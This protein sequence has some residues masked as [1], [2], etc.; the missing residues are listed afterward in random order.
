MQDFGYDAGEPDVLAILQYGSNFSSMPSSS[1]NQALYNVGD[2]YTEA[3]YYT[4]SLAQWRV[5]LGAIG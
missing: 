1:Y 5:V 3:G 2:K 4:V